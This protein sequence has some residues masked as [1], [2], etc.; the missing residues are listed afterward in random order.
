MIQNLYSELKN[1]DFMLI[2]IRTWEGMENN[3]SKNVIGKY[4]F[5]IWE[6]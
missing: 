1:G 2:Q 5:R 3:A 6:L 4:T